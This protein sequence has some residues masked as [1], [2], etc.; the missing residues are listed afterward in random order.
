M[1]LADL[2]IRKKGVR[3]PASGL[4]MKGVCRYAYENNE[5]KK[6]DSQ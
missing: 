4:K 1:L 6:L 3:L 5:W 2:D